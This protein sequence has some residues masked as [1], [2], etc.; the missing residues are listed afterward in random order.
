MRSAQAATQEIHPL[1]ERE[2]A[3][4]SRLAY[5]HFGLEL[6]RGKQELVSARLGK[7]VRAAGCRSFHEYYERVLED[8][9]GETW[10]S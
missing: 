3:D 4:I 7:K 2:F 6:K 9:T 8:R 1:T 5:E 10:S